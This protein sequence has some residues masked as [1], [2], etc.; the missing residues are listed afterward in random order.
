MIKPTDDSIPWP[1]SSSPALVF[2]AE[3]PDITKQWP[4]VPPCTTKI[5]GSKNIWAHQNSCH[6]V[7]LNL[8]WLFHSNN[9]S[10]CVCVCIHIHLYMQLFV[11]KLSVVICVY[12]IISL[13]IEMLLIT[14]IEILLITFIEILLITF[15]LLSK[16]YSCHIY[17]LFPLYQGY[18]LFQIVF[19]IFIIDNK[20]TLN[21]YICIHTH[22]YVNF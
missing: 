21:I 15:K 16:F 11:S 19:N 7:P 6:F 5:L 14:F 17:S 1:S 2:P 18:P 22:K 9:N 4:A 10:L 13:E 12:N 20:S 3:A 8:K